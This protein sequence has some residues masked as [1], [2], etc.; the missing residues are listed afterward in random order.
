VPE[1]KLTG[2]DGRFVG[3]TQVATLLEAVGVNVE[4]DAI[5]FC[6]TGHWAALGWFAR[7]EILGQKNVKV[8]DGSMV[9]WT[10][11]PE[12]PVEVKAE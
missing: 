11:R 2:A 9:D 1:S 3:A 6:N 10:A 12:L 5:S 7:S 4:D 8:Y